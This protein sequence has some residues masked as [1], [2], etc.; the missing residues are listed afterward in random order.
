MAIEE[1]GSKCDKNKE[2]GSMAMLARSVN[3][4]FEVAPSKTEDF[5]RETDK[6]A[7]SKAIE[8]FE[9]HT[10]KDKNK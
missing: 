8:R 4:P 6:T 7:F 5:F 9:L 1:D 10:K 2:D 3:F